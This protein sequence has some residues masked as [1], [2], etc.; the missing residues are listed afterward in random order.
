MPLGSFLEDALIHT[1]LLVG[2]SVADELGKRSGIRRFG[3]E[4]YIAHNDILGQSQQT[5]KFLPAYLLRD[6]VVNLVYPGPKEA[7]AVVVI[8]HQKVQTDGFS[9][10]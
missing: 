7:I 5:L 2:F 1:L 3:L 4:Q 10:L 6:V 8:L 9:K